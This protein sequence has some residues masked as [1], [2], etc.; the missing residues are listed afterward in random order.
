MDRE[1][2]ATVVRAGSGWRKHTAELKGLCDGGSSLAE[3]LFSQCVADAVQ[4]EVNEQ[5]VLGLNTIKEYKPP[6]G[7]KMS[8]VH[9]DRLKADILQKVS[10]ISGLLL[11][12]IR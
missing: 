9:I 10:A 11:Q 1:K 7:A 8:L 2:L 4:E 6:L 12:N 3:Y 5:F